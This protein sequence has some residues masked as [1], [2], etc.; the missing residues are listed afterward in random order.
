M[1][2]SHRA[3]LTLYCIVPVLIETKQMVQVPWSLLDHMMQ[4]RWLV[5]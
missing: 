5:L 4:E 2:G 1:S 3:A